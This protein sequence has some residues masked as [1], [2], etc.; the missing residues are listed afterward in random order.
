MRVDLLVLGPH[1][2]DIEIGFGGSIAKHVD[3]GYRVGLCDLTRGELG[4]NGT[5][6]ERNDEAL[7]AAQALGVAW[8]ENLGWADGEIGQDRQ[9]VRS[10]VELIR[11]CRPAVVAI[12]YGHDRHPDH[13]AANRVLTDAVFRSGLRRDTAEGAPWRPDWVCHY[14]INDLADPSFV[15]DVSDAYPRKCQALECHRSQFRP[16]SDDAVQTRLTGS[17]FL[18]MIEARDAHLGALAGVAHAEGVVVKEPVVRPSLFKTWDAA[19]D[20]QRDPAA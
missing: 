16:T 5:I 6:E 11:R 4:S 10:A 7:A 19:P 3:L 17:A 1:P 14:F 18:R 20:R 8:R 13:E 9:H 2:D 15:I 12:P